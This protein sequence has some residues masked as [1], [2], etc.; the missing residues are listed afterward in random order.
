MEG[1]WEMSRMKKR[2]ARHRYY[3]VEVKRAAVER[4]LAGERPS[5]VLADL[6]CSRSGL[7]QW[8]AEWEE[9]GGELWLERRHRRYP[10]GPPSPPGSAQREAELERLIG[11]QQAELDFLRDALRRIERV[12]RPTVE[13]R[14]PSPGS[15]SAR[16]RLGHKA[17]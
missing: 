16:G 6:G 11:Q 7:Y 15:S 13:P 10:P 1:E 3:P 4:L 8:R 14:A 2:V 5:Q 17:S 12:Q 9:N